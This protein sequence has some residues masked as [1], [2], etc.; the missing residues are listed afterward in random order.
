MKQVTK[1]TEFIIGIDFGHGE[2]SACFYDLKEGSE[3][4]KDLDIYGAQNEAYKCLLV[5]KVVN[6]L[7]L[8]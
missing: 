7:C 4:Q 2:T 3:P 8:S 1:D 5:D 6:D